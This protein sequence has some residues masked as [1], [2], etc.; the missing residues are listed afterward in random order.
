MLD[1]I[2]NIPEATFTKLCL[3]IFCTGLIAY[4]GFIIH[5][6]ARDSQAGR[7]GTLVLF[8]V[9]GLGTSGFVFK[10]LLNELIFI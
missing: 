4:M 7:T 5:R 6:L 2:L 3:G 9:L 8:L 1:A 10:T